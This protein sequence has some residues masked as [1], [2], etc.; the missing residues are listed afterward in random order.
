LDSARRAVVTGVGLIAPIGSSAETF[1]RSIRECTCGIGPVEAFDTSCFRGDKAGEVKGFDPSRYLEGDVIA[2]NG[3]RH[4][5]MA[6]AAAREAVDTAGYGKGF[7]GDARAAVSVGTCNGGLRTAELR[8]RML[9]GLEEG[10]LDERMNELQRYSALGRALSSLFDAAGPSLVVTTACASSTNALGVALDL[11]RSGKADTVLAGG[12]DALCMTT[13]SGFSAVKAMAPGNPCSPFSGAP[14]EYGMNLGEGAAFWV[15]EALDRALERGTEVLG[16]VMGYGLSGDA[17]HMT[18]PDPRGDGACMSMEVALADAGLD[19]S[20]IGAINAHGT[21]TEAND[22]A[23]SRAVRR[24]LGSLA[25][26]VP[27]SSL[28]SYF[29]HSLG[30]AGIMEA[31]ASLFGMQEGFVPPT[32]NFSGP[33]PG[34]EAIHVPDEPLAREHST[35]LSNSFA[36]SG[37]NASLVVGLHDPERQI[38]ARR[39]RRVVVTGA[40]AMSSLGAGISA[41]VS[42]VSEGRSGVADVDRFD[43][44][45]CSSRRAGLVPDVDWKRHA[46]RVDLRGMNRISRYATIA[47][48]EA[49]EQS[50]RR[51]NPRSMEDT[52]LVLGVYVGPS[53]EKLMETVWGTPDH[54]PDI[55]NFTQS[56]ANSINGYVSKALYMKGYNTMISS[57]HQAGLAAA[58]LG[59]EAVRTGRCSTVVTGGADEL[60]RRYYEDYDTIGLLGRDLNIEGRRRVLAEGAAMLVMEDMDRVIERDAV[61]LAEVLGWAQSVDRGDLVEG[62]SKFDGLA[63]AITETIEQGGCS[64]GD[65]DVVASA[66]MFNQGDAREEAAYR[67][68]FGESDAPRVLQIAGYTGYAESCSALMAATAWLG[69]LNASCRGP[70]LVVGTSYQGVNNVLL[71]GPPGR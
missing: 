62:T 20:G 19:V 7:D 5:L 55:T 60:F 38:S 46:G 66:P 9:L 67:E 29:G 53:T 14:G 28:K 11:V 54:V 70:A 32:L 42:G 8:Y 51:V 34:C 59:Y 40:G 17:Y 13:Y 71:L 68:V 49:L 33:R 26:D 10:T 48:K 3:D 2:A 30:A 44:S 35:F 45:G 65:I 22:K 56:V 64:P 4:I 18:A 69:G 52:G 27:V 39:V 41:L 25:R 16:E 24:I 1:R 43:T 47:A 36:F 58:A 21:G 15:V 31:T 12:S 63:R 50:G 37:N 61:P 6:L 57:G 23:E